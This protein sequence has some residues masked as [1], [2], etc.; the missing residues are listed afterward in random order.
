MPTSRLRL[1][2]VDALRH[3]AQR[4]DVEARVGLVEDRDLRLQ[5]RHLQ[6]LVALLLA[7]GEALVDAALGERR[8][9]LEVG[10][11]TLDLLDPVPHLR[12]LAAR[13][14]G[15]GA[16]EVRHRDAGDLDRV[17]HGEEQA[18][19][20]ALVDGHL[21]DVL[22]VEEDL[23]L[24][25]RVLRVARDRVRQ[26]RLA[27]TVRTHDRVGL[28]RV[29]GEVDTAQDLLGTGLGLD[30]DVQVADL[31]G[32]HQASFGSVRGGGGRSRQTPTTSSSASMAAS[33]RSRSAGT[34]T[35][36]MTSPKK[37]RTTSRRAWASGI[38][39]AIR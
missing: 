33:R 35:F 28:V 25:H 11:R 24:G 8:V 23:A 21:E 17:L 36:W 12:R 3:D 22:A 20:G 30:L 14:G 29:H 9:D 37:P 18:G 13:G 26:R 1:V 27:G 31:E 39:R 38:P 6:H 15:G 7:A 2:V 34:R 16:Q 4:V 19:A 5:Q 10:H 32:G